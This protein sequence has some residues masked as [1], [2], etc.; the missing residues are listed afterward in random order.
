MEIKPVKENLEQRSSAQLEQCPV[1]LQR[2]LRD[3]CDAA[4]D[5][6]QLN[7]PVSFQPDLLKLYFSA[8]RLLRTLES[9]REGYAFLLLQK[10]KN[11]FF[12]VYC[13]NPGPGLADGFDRVDASVC[14]SAT[15]A[16]QVYFKTL[17]GIADSAAWYQ[18]ESPF[19][20]ENLG[21]FTTS[22]ISTTY[23]ARTD[24]LYELVDTI[25]TVISARTGNYMVFFPSYAYLNEVN[26]KFEE[27]YMEVKTIRQTPSMSEQDREVFLHTF[28]E[29][30]Q[31]LLGFAVMGGVFGE[32]IDL[33]GSRLIGAIIVGVGLPQLGLERDLIRDYFNQDASGQNTIS[34]NNVSEN[35][36]ST[37]NVSRNNVST[38]NGFEFAYQYPG[39]NRVLQTAGRVIRSETDRGVVCLIDHR[40]NETRYQQLLPSTWKPERARSRQQLEQHL[41]SFWRGH[42][43]AND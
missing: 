22:F 39:M 15:M 14:F 36:V 5:W 1:S 12:K 37:N 19:A 32:G 8:I 4:E 26:G 13:L 20:A 7:Q 21:V 43:G 16:P 23:K 35:N 42:S 31:T 17:M 40:F 41:L 6:L 28:E 18:I 33:K 30:N 24:S 11:T 9:A 29:M 3:F 27:R 25:K 38:N 2:A 34:E 10:N